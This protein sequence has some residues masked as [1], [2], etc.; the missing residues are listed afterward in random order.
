LISRHKKG[1]G[2][3]Y[4]Q[5]LDELK[6]ELKK[7]LASFKKEIISTLRSL[8]NDVKQIQKTQSEGGVTF[9][10]KRVVGAMNAVK[11]IGRKG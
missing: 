8:S 11:E 6:M 10:G 1:W 4:Y 2:H 7:E 9:N 5:A 3:P